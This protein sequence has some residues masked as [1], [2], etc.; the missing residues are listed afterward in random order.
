MEEKH[1][2]ESYQSD[3]TLFPS[4]GIFQSSSPASKDEITLRLL[5]KTNES[6]FQ[7]FLCQLFFDVLLNVQSICVLNG[8]NGA[9]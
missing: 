1:N 3:A 6:V 8:I 4:L 5:L 9:C 2:E 7:F